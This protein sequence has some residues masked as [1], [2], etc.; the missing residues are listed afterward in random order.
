[1]DSENS[2]TTP[3]LHMYVPPR[4]VYAGGVVMERLSDDVLIVKESLL[5][6]VAFIALA[7]T[8]G[9]LSSTFLYWFLQPLLN[10]QGRFDIERWLVVGVASLVVLFSLALT[11]KKL[12]IRSIRMD[13]GRGELSYKGWFFGG[14][15]HRLSELIA[16][17]VCY[18][19]SEVDY[20][21]RRPRRITLQYQ[22]NLVFQN[23]D[24]TRRNVSQ[25]KYPDRVKRVAKQLAKFLDVPLVNYVGPAGTMEA[26]DAEIRRLLVGR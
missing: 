12:F 24:L 15:E 3:L 10:V 1:M 25:Q 11:L 14:W 23:S 8:I 26:G 16:I 13:H 2:E 7:A 6:R 9:A 18:G 4:S 20:P 21:E 17:Q 22:V 5:S 19:K